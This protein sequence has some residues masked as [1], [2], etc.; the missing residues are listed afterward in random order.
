MHVHMYVAIKKARRNKKRKSLLQS[1]IQMHTYIVIHTYH[2]THAR[3]TKKKLKRYNSY[4]ISTT[5]LL[6]AE[7][8][9][10]TQ[11][12]WLL[13][14]PFRTITIQ[15]RAVPRQQGEQPSRHARRP[16]ITERPTLHRKPRLNPITAVQQLTSP[17]PTLRT[18]FLPAATGRHRERR[19]DRRCCWVRRHNRHRLRRTRHSRNAGP[20]K[21][22][23]C[24]KRKS[25]LS[26]DM[27]HG[28][29]GKNGYVMISAPPVTAEAATC[30]RRVSRNA[31]RE[32]PVLW[33][34]RRRSNC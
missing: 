17:T 18:A 9:L 28:F 5:T 34:N 13:V 29:R 7:S 6:A 23:P 11:N 31:T 30:K 22:L 32:K 25:N 2:T 16:S 1:T 4:I 20:S 15:L 12:S 10:K 33:R 21:P 24:S 27:T 26:L 3:S 14:S 8:T 19:T